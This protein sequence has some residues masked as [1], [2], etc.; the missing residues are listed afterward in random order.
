MT[1]LYYRDDCCVNCA[2]A[3]KMAKELKPFLNIVYEND[4]KGKFSWFMYPVLI[5]RDKFYYKEK[6]VEK[7]AKIGGDAIKKRAGEVK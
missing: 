5:H 1:K 6:C 2:M 3:L 7:L 4:K